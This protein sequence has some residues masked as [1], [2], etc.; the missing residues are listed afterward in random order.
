MPGKEGPHTLF[1]G[2]AGTSPQT[3]A[4]PGLCAVQGVPWNWRPQVSPALTLL[5]ADT[6]K[7]RPHSGFLAVP[8]P[9]LSH[10]PSP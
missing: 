9:P 3:P 7:R 6:W 8:V 10:F 2:C 4:S 5:R 1:S